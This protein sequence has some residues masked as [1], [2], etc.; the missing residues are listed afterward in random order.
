MLKPKL[1]VF[2]FI[3]VNFYFQ[4]FFNLMM[5]LY[6]A[7]ITQDNTSLCFVYRKSVQLTFNDVISLDMY[8]LF[9][10]LFSQG[11]V[12]LALVLLI[13][14]ALLPDIIFML[15]GRH[16]HPSETQKVQVTV[17]RIFNVN[18]KFVSGRYNF[19]EFESVCRV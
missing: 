2:F 9:F 6:I 16:F 8:K 15:I 19:H 12:W 17:L 14:M 18:E 11:V 13:L 7:K 10:Q 3:L 1:K 4:V 5:I